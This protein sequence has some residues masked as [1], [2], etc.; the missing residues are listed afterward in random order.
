MIDPA[1]D[2]NKSYAG[3]DRYLNTVFKLLEG[4]ADIDEAEKCLRDFLESEHAGQLDE[5]LEDFLYE[6]FFDK[7]RKYFT[8]SAN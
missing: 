7:C 2:P 6:L 1:A 3:L 5:N 8:R 4:I